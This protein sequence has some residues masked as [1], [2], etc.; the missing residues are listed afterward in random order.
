MF[1]GLALPV[2]F[3][4]VSQRAP[5]P[6]SFI[7]RRV[8]SVHGL[9]HQIENDPRVA[10]RY[11]RYFSESK[12][13]VEHYIG[14][15]HKVRLADNE[16]FTMYS[17]PQSGA[18]RSH[19]LVLHKGDEV[20]ANS[21]NVPVIRLDCGNPILPLG[22]SLFNRPAPLTS[23]VVSSLPKVVAQTVEIPET[24]PSPEMVGIIPSSPIPPITQSI[25]TAVVPPPAQFLA[26]SLHGSTSALPYFLALTP[27]I[28]IFSGS[29]HSPQPVPLPNN[30]VILAPLGLV[31]M[32]KRKR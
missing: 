8:S 27:L 5:E 6:N 21:D 9:V 3:A 2:V 22:F 24:Q 19:D 11:M 16:S 12:P 10:D 32:C 20:L 26:A 18:I 14:S 25:S 17:V 30:L 15:L 28:A 13:E 23:E 29:G 4:T 31:L 1:Y 7:D